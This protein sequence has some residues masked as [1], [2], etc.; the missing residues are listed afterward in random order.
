MYKSRKLAPRKVGSGFSECIIC[1]TV[2][3]FPENSPE[4]SHKIVV[5]GYAIHTATGKKTKTRQETVHKKLERYAVD[6]LC[7]RLYEEC[8]PKG[9]P[10]NSVAKGKL[11][12]SL[13]G[14]DLVKEGQN[15]F[16]WAESTAGNTA[17]R[18]RTI[19]NLIDLSGEDIS[20]ENIN[21]IIQNL[22]NKAMTSK[23]S[24]GTVLTESRFW[25]SIMRAANLYDSVQK[26]HC[27]IGLPEI[28]WP[29]AVLV[30]SA[31]VEQV[32]SLPAD[33]REKLASYLASNLHKNP[34]VLGAALMYYCGLRNAEACAI[35]YGQIQRITSPAGQY[36]YGCAWVNIEY[37]IYQGVRTEYLKSTNAYRIV[38]IPHE[39]VKMI[40]W[41][42]D[43]LVSMGFSE[44]EIYDLPIT[45]VKFGDSKFVD[46]QVLADYV[47]KALMDCGLSDEYLA[48]AIQ[49]QHIYP[50]LID[51][52]E[53]GINTHFTAYILRRDAATRY[54]TICGL[55]P[56][57]V[58][59]LL[60]HKKLKDSKEIHMTDL[61]LQQHVAMALSRYCP[62]PEDS[63]SP[64][65]KTIALS[66]DSVLVLK[67]HTH[68]EIVAAENIDVELDV[69]SI[70]TGSQI[71]VTLPAGSGSELNG[72]FTYPTY[73]P[74]IPVL[75]DHI[76]D[77]SGYRRYAAS[78]LSYKGKEDPANAEKPVAGPESNKEV[79]TI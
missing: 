53:L 28:P 14:I 13:S 69:N 20:P 45:A 38:I 32:K 19:L 67:D 30:S 8:R 7:S 6:K 70:E 73:V 79:E 23:Q 3:E 42:H 57:I 31:Q 50:D 18:L 12:S 27:N 25:P 47:V 66:G 64:A 26:N 16:C 62:L 52:P 2:K 60:G 48:Q 49:M 78:D 35:T 29:E 59:Y 41:M 39:A 22:L 37:Q 4:N 54:S 5:K 56:D 9:A 72:K 71:R 74:G 65:V 44:E 58:D 46:P 34:M 1:L 43:Q 11:I 24:D 55:S 63:L 17:S 51:V 75:S 77:S 33:V 36:D 21:A 61:T 68:Y 10:K 40:D 15:S 76:G